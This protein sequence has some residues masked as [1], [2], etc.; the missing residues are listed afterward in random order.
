MSGTRPTDRRLFEYRA[1]RTTNILTHRRTCV[2]NESF[3]KRIDG[4]KTKTAKDCQHLLYETIFQQDVK[5]AI[6]KA[7]F[8]KHVD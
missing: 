1:L 5:K 2:V 6:R 8:V 4:S 7:G 3:H